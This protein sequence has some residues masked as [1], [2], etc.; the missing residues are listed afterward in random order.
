VRSLDA[1]IDRDLEYLDLVYMFPGASIGD[2]AMLSGDSYTTAQSHVRVLMQARMV[3][4]YSVR[5]A[6]GMYMVRTVYPA[7]E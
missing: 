1:L 6:S 4:V 3:A 7:E 5:V 2:L